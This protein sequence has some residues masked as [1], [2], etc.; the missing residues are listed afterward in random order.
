MGGHL[1]TVTA[2]G[3]AHRDTK[4]YPCGLHLPD[5]NSDGITP[6]RHHRQPST[7]I[8]SS[9]TDDHNGKPVSF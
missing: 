4:S 1:A 5:D 9:A 6:P 8:A 7:R 3:R 2:S